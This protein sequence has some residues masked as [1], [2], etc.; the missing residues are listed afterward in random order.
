MQTNL[1]ST[2]KSRLFWAFGNTDWS[3]PL[4]RAISLNQ[5]YVFWA[6][7]CSARPRYVSRLPGSGRT[8]SNATKE[9]NRVQIRVHDIDPDW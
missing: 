2:T 3:T 5:H 9:V 4:H 1:L 6:N 7:G 8:I